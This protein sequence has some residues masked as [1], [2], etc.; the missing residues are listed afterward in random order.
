MIGRKTFFSLSLLVAL[1]AQAVMGTDPVSF[2]RPETGTINCFELSTGNVYPAVCTPWGGGMW[3][4]STKPG[5]REGWFYD[6]T[7]RQIYGIR[8]TF[9]P[10]PWAGDF[11]QW[12]FLPVKGEVGQK[13]EERF[14]RYSHKTETLRPDYY[15]VYLVDSDATLELTPSDRGACVRVTYPKTDKPGF[16]V[17]SFGGEGHVEVTAD[18]RRVTGWSTRHAARAP[19]GFRN[20]FVLEFDRPVV[21]SVGDD[22]WKALRFAPMKRGDV[23]NVRIASSFISPEQAVRNLGELAGG[24]DK[25]R[26]AARKRWNKVLGRLDVET[27]DVDRKRMFY[28]C[29]YRAV[30]FPRAFWDVG[31]DGKSVH[32]NPET[33]KVAPG[34]YYAGTGFWDTFRSLFPLLN[35]AYPEVNERMMAGLE[36]S[37]REAGWLP[38]WSNPGFWDCMVGNNSASVVADAYLSGV[39]KGY[40][41]EQLWQAVVHGAE[42]AH[43]SVGSVGRKGVGDYLSLGYV[44]CDV[45][46]GGAT[47]RTL[48]YAY[49]DWCIWKFGEA[50]GKP[51]AEIARFRERS[52][53]WRK[54]FDPVHKFA[55]G[56]KKDG[57]FNRNF[58]P[59]RW[60]GELVEGDSWQ[61]SWCVFHD[62][63][64]LAELLGG[65]KAMGERLDA[66][67]ATSSAD[68]AKRNGFVI[69]EMT[70]M[71][72]MDFG[73]Y[74]HGNQPVQ[75]AI[76][77]Y[78]WTDRPS[79]AQHWV[80][81]VMD[82]LYKPQPDGYCGDEDNGQTSAWYVWSALG[83]Y[84]V[85]P[86]SGEYALGSPAV[87]KAVVSVRNGAKLTIEAPGASVKR[88][89]ASVTFNGRPVR[90]GRLNQAEL[91]KGGKLYFKMSDKPNQ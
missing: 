85:C 46:I 3:T 67:F 10:S 27:P 71:Q 2:V 56:R 50:L 65:K 41:A 38:E 13:Q 29:L 30:L 20:Y 66:M 11:G 16:V 21:E 62:P 57:S 12:S 55:N 49:D 60:S 34:Y 70:E 36:S 79:R 48:E 35:F 22:K 75:H 89:V 74:A 58:D 31:A 39:R 91:L 90:N 73:E 53:N 32:Y 64:G 28:T 87:E 18:R 78:N 15:R 76:Y 47:A 51:E 52:Q 37:W 88:Y 40:D 59:G 80:R 4:L 61:W 7:H 6:Y 23:L 1:S 19:E 8:Q 5:H 42:N 84:P 17:D 77:F 69:H 26:E 86:G 14:S 9:Q 54:V 68:A 33:G 82:R 72:I 24:F 25:T 81:E 63:E 83:F 45:K 44:P 43:P